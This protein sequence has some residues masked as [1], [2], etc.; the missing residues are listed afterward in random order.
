[1]VIKD[2][3][4]NGPAYAY[5]P[6]TM[7][8][9]RQ[10]LAADPAAL[11][12]RLN[13]ATG[14]SGHDSIIAGALAVVQKS[15]LGPLAG[16]PIGIKDNI[17]VEGFATTGGSPA[18]RDYRPS[19]DAPV[20]A[21]LRNAGAVIACKLNMHELALGVTSDNPVFGRVCN[22]F[23]KD[24][25]AGGS[26]G[27]S[28]S[29]VAHGL[30]PVALGTDTGGSVRIPASFCGVVGFRPSTGRYPEGGVLPLCPRRDT[31][32]PIA[33]S[34]GDIAQIDAAIMEEPDRLPPAPARRFR[35]GLPADALPGLSPTIEIAF[36]AVLDGL[37]ASGEVTVVPLPELGLDGME[38]DIGLPI[39]LHEAGRVWSEF[40]SRHL[41][42]SLSEFAGRLADPH[43]RETFATLL[44]QIDTQTTSNPVIGRELAALRVRIGALYLDHDI[45][46]VVMPTCVVQPPRWEDGTTLRIGG[47]EHSTFFTVVRNACLSTLTGGPSLSLPAGL[48][49]DGLPVGL[50]LDGPANSDRMLL[51]MAAQL[52]PYLPRIAGHCK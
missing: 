41:N 7:A 30:V 24:R 29:A 12:A 47:A 35:L 31:V 38:R 22:P 9:I 10:D 11:A 20:V 17:D 13:A 26:S 43:V 6:V 37:A 45:D 2:M 4:A 18:L 14:Q 48:D 28:A 23:D 49:E 39:V 25:T 33:A 27:G 1:M 34:V 51:S 16:I 46:L 19:A 32:G 52:E 5:D 15:R 50:M 36:R 42:C 21:A 44:L 40:C 3:T 8:R